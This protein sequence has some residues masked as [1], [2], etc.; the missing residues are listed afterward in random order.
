M[1]VGVFLFLHHKGH[2]FFF[3]ET[4]SSFIF[5]CIVRKRTK[6]RE[7]K[8]DYLLKWSGNDFCLYVVDVELELNFYLLTPFYC[9]VLFAMCRIIYFGINHWH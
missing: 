3:N 1:N 2:D 9:C 8:F 4:P 5:L 7:Y 6:V